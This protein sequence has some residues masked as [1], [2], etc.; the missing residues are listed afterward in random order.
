MAFVA[1][2]VPRTY[3]DAASSQQRARRKLL[4]PRADRADAASALAAL[5]LSRASL[6]DSVQQHVSFN[7][8]ITKGR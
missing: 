8:K 6:T 3:R 7:D 5:A 1:T 2:F 4:A